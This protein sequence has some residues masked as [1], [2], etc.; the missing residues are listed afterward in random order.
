MSRGSG[1]PQPLPP[2][3]C[4]SPCGSEGGVGKGVPQ[5]PQWF[6]WSAQRGIK[7]TNSI[8]P[9]PFYHGALVPL[10]H[11]RSQCLIIEY[12]T[13]PR[14]DQPQDN[15]SLDWLQDDRVALSHHSMRV[16]LPD[17]RRKPHGKLWRH[18]KREDGIGGEGG[19]G[20]TIGGGEGLQP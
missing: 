2:T 10:L 11:T 17:R 14:R 13:L 9:H 6:T 5:Q 20:Y 18:W 4:G 8:A 1:Q 3:P 7:D 19:G 12:W 16:E 15:K